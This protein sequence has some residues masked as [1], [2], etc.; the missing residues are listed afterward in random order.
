M[1]TELKNVNIVELA[2]LIYNQPTV[3][4][5]TN[6]TVA[7]FMLK[8]DNASGKGFKLVPITTWGDNAKKIAESFVKGDTI[9]LKGEIETGS[10]KKDGNT[11]FT[12]GV[13]AQEI[14]TEATPF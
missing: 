4:D 6:S 2:G 5:T 3:R 9:H 10:Y 14:L 7:K 1:T 8:V 13:L 12:W 11:I